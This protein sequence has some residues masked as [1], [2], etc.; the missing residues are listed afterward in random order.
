MSYTRSQSRLSLHFAV[1]GY[2]L[3][4]PTYSKLPISLPASSP[5]CAAGIQLPTLH[6]GHLP[7][8][9][10][11]LTDTDDSDWC[12]NAEDT[13]PC[14]ENSEDNVQEQAEDVDKPHDHEVMILLAFSLVG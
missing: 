11:Q 4:I 1:V 5:W 12:D 7:P 6:A 8:I 13:D 10:A 14:D 3:T 2:G 9:S